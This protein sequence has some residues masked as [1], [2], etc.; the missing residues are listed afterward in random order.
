MPLFDTTT[1]LL[2]YNQLFR[3]ERFVGL[4]RVGDADQLTLG[5]STRLLSAQSGQ[6]Y[7]S[8]SLGKTFLC[9]KAQGRFAG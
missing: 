5:I 4:D 3:K 1:M 8:Y 9:A 6:E 7:G 2:G